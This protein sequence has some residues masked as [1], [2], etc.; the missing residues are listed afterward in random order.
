MFWIFVGRGL[1]VVAL[2][3]AISATIMVVKG[4]TSRKNFQAWAII[5]GGAALMVFLFLTFTLSG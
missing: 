4:R 5:W 3:A 2:I 1:L